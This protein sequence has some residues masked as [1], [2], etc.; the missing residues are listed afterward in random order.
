VTQGLSHVTRFKQCDT[1]F[2]Q[3]DI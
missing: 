2:K 1:R 3:C